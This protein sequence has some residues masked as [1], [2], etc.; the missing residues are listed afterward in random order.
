MSYR[1]GYRFHVASDT[2]LNVVKH[3]RDLPP[4]VEEPHDHRY[5][6][7]S[8]VMKGQLQND[9]WT[10]VA[11]TTGRIVH[12]SCDGEPVTE[13]DSD[14]CDIERLVSFKISLGCE[15]SMAHDTFHTITPFYAENGSCIT[16]LWRGP[17][18]KRLVHV[19]QRV[20]AERTCPFS[21][22]LNETQCW[23]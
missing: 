14:L 21:R 15:Y 17:K 18:V 1:V 13:S 2:R 7:T 4:F 23:E 9:I 12:V 16:R 8:R 5:W 3:H 10:P 19:F 22:P 20:D 6:F 11:G